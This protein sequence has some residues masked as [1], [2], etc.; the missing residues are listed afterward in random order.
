MMDLSPSL[1]TKMEDIS[2]VRERTG[3]H[4]LHARFFTKSPNTFVQR[5]FVRRCV[6][7]VLVL[8]L[9]VHL[10]Q[11]T[12]LLCSWRFEIAEE[13]HGGAVGHSGLCQR[14]VGISVASPFAATASED[15]SIIGQW[16]SGQ[17]AH[18]HFLPQD[19]DRPLQR[20]L[21]G[22]A[23]ALAPVQQR[24]RHLHDLATGLRGARQ[25]LEVRQEED[26]F[27]ALV[28]ACL[29]QG[30]LGILVASPLTSSIAEDHSIG[31]WTG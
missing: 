27:A 22:F 9:N 1:R 4:L 11:V 13:F 2:K 24:H 15:I 12:R 8:Q 25:R 19:P 23:P 14:Q 20:R 6:R 3:Q 10:H 31:G 29:S 16:P 21:G 5:G 17:A 18:S 7:L 30:E 28:D 26:G